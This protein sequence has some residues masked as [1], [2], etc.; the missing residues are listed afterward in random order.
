[1]DKQKQ[2][3][4]MT[5]ELSN[6]QTYA[7]MEIYP[8]DQKQPNEIVAEHLVRKGWIKPD[9]NV[10]VI[11]REEWE[12]RAYVRAMEND[13]CKKCRERIG[14]E[15]EKIER[16]SYVKGNSLGYHNGY[17]DGS[18]ETT[19][20]IFDELYTWL[21]LEEIEKYGFVQIQKFDFLR[22]FREIIA[23]EQQDED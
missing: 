22:K 17:L 9:E 19:A 1:M 15:Y 4:E 14:E 11:T 5:R 8:C 7:Y 12:H 13:L 2:I 23:G 18:K 3:E 16:D 20:K 6:I 10:V 21:D